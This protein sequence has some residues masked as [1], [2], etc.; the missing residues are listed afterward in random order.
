MQIRPSHGRQQSD[1]LWWAAK[2]VCTLGSHGFRWQSNRGHLSKHQKPEMALKDW[3]MA[4]KNPSCFVVSSSKHL[5]SRNVRLTPTLPKKLVFTIRPSFSTIIF[6]CIQTF[7]L[8]WQRFFLWGLLHFHPS[9]GFMM[10]HASFHKVLANVESSTSPGKTKVG[11]QLWSPQRIKSD[12][13]ICLA[14]VGYFFEGG[15]WC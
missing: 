9:N 2:S 12:F 3:E 8:R 7:D 11:V 6:T 14:D 4:L 13:K 10:F 5:H 15:G 1:V